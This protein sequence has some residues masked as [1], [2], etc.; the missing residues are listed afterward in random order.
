MD[1]YNDNLHI[2]DTAANTAADGDADTGHGPAPEMVVAANDA[3]AA[4]TVTVAQAVEHV[5]TP[6]AGEQTTVA[7]VPGTQYTF[8]FH[9]GDADFVFSDGNL[10]ILVHGGGEIILQG[11][12]S[13]ALGNQ[14]PALNFAG[15]IVGALDLLNQTASA[16]QL[17]E[18]QPAA[19]PGGGAVPAG[20][21][22]FSPFA[23][24]PLPPG[25]AE[26]G[27]IPPTSLAFIPP[28]LVPFVFPGLEAGRLIG[29]PVCENPFG[30]QL[31]NYFSDIPR[32]CPDDVTIPGS[33]FFDG[34]T[35]GTCGTSLND[36]LIGDSGHDYINGRG[37]DDLIVGN[38]GDDCLKGGCGDD[39][40]YGDEINGYC[41]GDDKIDGGDGNDIIV[42][43][44][45]CDTIAGDLIDNCGYANLCAFV[46][47][48]GTF[49]D[50][51]DTIFGGWGSDKIAGDVYQ[52]SGGCVDLAAIAGCFGGDVRAFNDYISGGSG[53]DKIAGDVYQ[54]GGGFVGLHAGAFG[55]GNH[56]VFAFNDTIFGGGS[57]PGTSPDVSETTCGSNY[58]FKGDTIA[59]DVFQQ[60]YCEGAVACLSAFAAA[61][62]AQVY[63]FNDYIEGG[64]VIVGD[65]YQQGGGRGCFQADLKAEAMGSGD[66]LVF[67]FND[68]L[69]GTS[70][71]VNMTPHYD[72]EVCSQSGALLV[73]DVAQDGG[74]RD[75]A[76]LSAGASGFC[77]GGFG[78]SVCAFDDR[79][80]GGDKVVNVDIAP[81]ILEITTDSIGQGFVCVD[82]GNFSD[83]LVG[84]V[85]QWSEGGCGSVG[86]SAFA[87]GDANVVSA[88]SD[89]IV[90]G[91]D[92]ANITVDGSCAFITLENFF[93]DLLVGDV[94]Q[95]NGSAC[96]SADAYGSGNLI[97]AYMDTITGGDHI[98][99]L[100][101][102]NW[103]DAQVGFGGLFQEGF[104]GDILVGDVA[105]VYGE[106][107]H[108]SASA[109]GVSNHLCVYDDSITGGAD[110]VTMTGLFQQGYCSEFDLASLYGL[111]GF[112]DT[113]V[114]D[115]YQ[116]NFNDW[117]GSVC[118]NAE[119]CGE[120]NTIDGYN[121]TIIAGDDLLSLDISLCA[122]L[123]KDLLA[124]GPNCDFGSVMG[125]VLVGDVLESDSWGYAGASV[126]VY[127]YGNEADTYDDAL[128][129]GTHTIDLNI[130]AS[131]FC[132]NGL[133][134]LAPN[135]NYGDGKLFA[136]TFVG[137]ILQNNASC[138]G[139]GCVDASVQAF[140]AYN[141]TRAFDDI[142]V[143]GDQYLVVN[144]NVSAYDATNIFWGFNEG[145]CGDVSLFA[146]TLVGD[147]MQVNGNFGQGSVNLS[148]ETGGYHNVTYAFDDIIT[149]AA[150]EQIIVNGTISAEYGGEAIG[151]LSVPQDGSGFSVFADTLVGDVFQINGQYQGGGCVDLSAAICGESNFLSAFNDVIK[152]AH[153]YVQM[154][155]DVSIASGY[156]YANPFLALAPFNDVL[157]GDVLQDNG[158]CGWGHVGLD[159]S[160]SGCND[161][162]AA[163]N[164]VIMGG[165]HDFRVTYTGDVAPS[166]AA[167][168]LPDFGDTL[169]GDSYQI[170]G[171]CA[172]LAVKNEG[173]S[174]YYDVFNDYITL[175]TSMLTVTLNGETESV[176]GLGSNLLV[177]DVAVQSGFAGDISLGVV[178]CWGDGNTFNA[179][180]DT[181][182]GGDSYFGWN[183]LV[184][185]VFVSAWKGSDVSLYVSNNC[186]D[187]NTFNAFNDLLLGGNGSNYA[188]GDVWYSVDCVDVCSA[189]NLN[190]KNAGGDG[191]TFNA[192]NDTAT[193]GSGYE[194][195][196]VGDVAYFAWNQ[197]A[198]VTLSV[199]NCGG[200]HNT[201]N[202]FNDHLTAGD[203]CGNT[204]VGDVW[205]ESSDPAVYGNAN[206]NAYSAVANS[207]TFN[208]FNDEIASGTGDDTLVGDVL[209]TQSG[210]YNKVDL[211]LGNMAAASVSTGYGFTSQGAHADYNTF[212]GFNDV[213]TGGGG[214]D[215]I[216]GDVS[217][218]QYGC[219]NKVELA[220]N[221]SAAAHA[222]VG[223]GQSPGTGT[224]TA[225]AHA[226]HNTFN[227]FND[228]LAG[229]AGIDG[230]VGDVFA[231]QSDADCNKVGLTIGN[232][233]A[234]C[235]VAAT[236]D[237]A[238]EGVLNAYAEGSASAN[239]NHFTA[240][241]DTI[242]GGDGVEN[243]L[244]GDVGATQS[245]CYNEIK[246]GVANSA[247]AHASDY[248]PLPS[249]DYAAATAL[250]Q[251]NE[252][253]FN[254]FNDVL[255]GGAGNDAITGDVSATQEGE[256][257]K[258]ELCVMNIAA[259]CAAWDSPGM[260][261]ATAA[262]SHNDF[263]LFNDT[264]SGA[265][266]S[267]YLVGDVW[268]YQSGSTNDID[269]GIR[270][271]ANAN[272]NGT[273]N[274][275]ADFNTF[276]AFND[277]I[278][279][280]A[281]A[282]TLVGD[283]RASQHDDTQNHI[284][285]YVSNA[286]HESGGTASANGNTFH[287]F[288]DSLTGGG[289]DDR[290][291]G[292]VSAYQSG[293]SN[294]VTFD[295]HN[296]INSDLG[297][298]SADNN[299]FV[300]FN[301]TIAGG[302]GNNFMVGDAAV[303]GTEPYV[304]HV[305]FT[306]LDEGGYNNTFTAFNDSIT[307]GS[308][309]DSITGDVYMASADNSIVNVTV[310]DT[311]GTDTMSLFND[312]L[313]GGGGDDTIVGD[314]WLGGSNFNL[315]VNGGD[316]HDTLF[317]D[318][319]SGGA[320]NDQLFGDFLENDALSGGHEHVDV[321]V[322]GDTTGFKL[323]ADTINGGAGDDTIDG[324]I[325]DDNLTGGTGND[326]FQ[327]SLHDTN[328]LT[329]AIDGNDG[330]D[331]VMDYN[332]GQGDVLQFTDVVHIGS[333]TDLQDI[334][335]SI[336]NISDDG[337][338]TTITF[339]NGA[340]I[341]LQGVSTGTANSN[342][343]FSALQAQVQMQV[344]H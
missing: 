187:G 208:V 261:M 51:N 54:R 117:S 46:D 64:Q 4:K 134:A 176:T 115:V 25:I 300:L 70:Y 152:G 16:E 131:F 8:D 189:V 78:Q 37:G 178:N 92:V 138:E 48:G 327:F 265:G 32:L 58:S 146:N 284:S 72:N 175:G 228:N 120:G 211:S 328:T 95:V 132:A 330:H 6:P 61:D 324:G 269:L 198:K 5:A 248:Q 190:V 39:T 225:T 89:T 317:C 215:Y 148:A 304:N 127:G 329:T 139:G 194:N 312:T 239:N 173:S 90:G 50:F 20:P 195:T 315:T 27:P 179:F 161:T 296:V 66:Q 258:I 321:S 67:A 319:I 310:N 129:G 147:V 55:P 59:G 274:A 165:V 128:V 68:Y 191:N 243:T 259:A 107:A 302:D 238:D 279:A 183:T 244:T 7:V 337:A 186:G 342:E 56:V 153:Q 87:E 109:S 45:G 263:T 242:V 21:A 256:Q 103:A 260:A 133:F 272:G 19:G 264:I 233:A 119:I 172:D 318:S 82:I 276:N 164:D 96:L 167:L 273:V 297:V 40:I 227:A 112:G 44:G 287:A 159:A 171:G 220:L 157:V 253:S 223:L 98:L 73:G 102:T 283:V 41:W 163:Y 340:S 289:G 235:A 267:N 154:N 245:G 316:G 246:L 104:S 280:G 247:N 290:L 162:M 336:S 156:A 74:W 221:N 116:E 271:S 335:A 49:R 252:N 75:S 309:A 344:A 285:L 76:Y 122:F 224:A 205:Y 214:S 130:D 105:Q 322:S 275:T 65:V 23:P 124:F 12:G 24:G 123:G 185:D 307:G 237:A 136:D 202:A 17:A 177:G 184:G 110:R 158:A 299:T 311:N 13:E 47:Y 85:Y 230:I 144:A 34:N 140:G 281:G 236:P 84:D 292:D 332:Q 294:T 60:S 323:F 216:A 234:A 303:Y 325:G 28:E 36:S 118:L 295:V 53:D 108:L 209:A 201:F 83:T 240:Y 250:A 114:G 196:L 286:A 11:Y 213:I 206:N 169:V 210:Y 257:N 268:A 35:E 219:T 69:I 86:L 241:N 298:A 266:G 166:F 282:D 29:A 113:M 277:V 226:D 251:A 204:I 168:L 137:D 126:G 149:G 150:R 101:L 203:A 26:I 232:S 79:I 314:L 255:V 125:D 91:D 1:S 151:E 334:Q 341:D 301:D 111:G 339:A 14:I 217:A 38:G 80:F 231:Q 10:I 197:G 333:N 145:S 155:F 141:V 313:S 3:P 18:I 106:G 288:N 15:D 199:E 31:A 229:G 33:S 254:A 320:G 192:F 160:I 188:A 52:P 305:N 2:A 193:V 182:L 174:N 338:N 180:D 270:N 57:C 262:A 121:D 218:Y 326:V 207:N 293:C 331:V 42:G 343:D 43:G 291:V 94:W 222:N 212:F 181:I 81:L 170:G 278:S 249:S 30:G 200:D 77:E 142:L 71:T 99:N 308:G 22:S 100:S 135:G 97:Y 9:Q 62:A 63:A 306:V 88:F 93:S 143:G